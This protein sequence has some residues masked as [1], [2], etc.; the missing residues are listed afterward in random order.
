MQGVKY[1]GGLLPRRHSG[2][3]TDPWSNT[4]PPGSRWPHPGSSYVPAGYSLLVLQ[5]LGSPG[6]KGIAHH[7]ARG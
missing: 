7:W 3:S 4:A 5:G 6:G 2:H 1:T